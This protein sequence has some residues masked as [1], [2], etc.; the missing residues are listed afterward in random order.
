MNKSYFYILIILFGFLLQSSLQLRIV[1][2]IITKKYHYS[3][4]WKAKKIKPDDL[5]VFRSRVDAK[6]AGFK[7]CKLCMSD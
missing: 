3:Y 6:I 5:V 4:C 2:S 1:G 7:P